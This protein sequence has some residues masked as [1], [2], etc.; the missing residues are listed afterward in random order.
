MSKREK[1][2]E[3]LQESGCINAVIVNTDDEKCYIQF[4]FKAN[5]QKHFID[6]NVIGFVAES[7]YLSA[8]NLIANI[9]KIKETKNLKEHYFYAKYYLPALFCF[10]QYLE[11]KLKLMYMKLNETQFL[12]GHKLEDLLKALKMLGFTHSC[13]E[14]PISFYKNIE[15]GCVELTRYMVDKRWVYQ[16]DL[17]ID[18]NLKEKLREWYLSI[19]QA[20]NMHFNQLF[21]KSLL[22]N[23]RKLNN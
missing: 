18:L 19:E 12:S 11:L 2:E 23:K 22:K 10:R 14:Q 16:K 20:S 1:E 21:I 6:R 9:E 13:F 4:E 7:Y 8:M 17:T 3:P 5:G 15:K